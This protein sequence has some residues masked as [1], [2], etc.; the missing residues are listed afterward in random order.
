MDTDRA[1]GPWGPAVVDGHRVRDREFLEFTTDGYL[2]TDTQGVIVEANRA[3]ATVLR[4]PKEFLIS[5]PLGLFMTV[6][7]R[8]RFYE[9]LSRLHAGLARDEFETR[10]GR[11][12][13][14]QRD[15]IV[16]VSSVD[17]GAGDRPAFRWLLRDITERR[18]AE[19]AREELL[20]RLVT[21]QE[22][23]RRRVAREL[24]DSV[25]QLLSAL[26]LG[27]RAVKDAG[28]LPPG[29]L[30]RLEEVNR[31]VGE[32][33]RATHDLAIGLRPTALDDVGLALALRQ[34]LEEWSAR[35][36]IE[37]QYEAVGLDSSRLPSEIETALYRVVQEALTNVV[38]H[39][40]ARRVSVVL[41]R[42]DGRAIAVVEDNGVGF[43]PEAAAESG[44]LGLIGM[45]ERVALV[46]GRLE[47][48][49][50]PGAGTTL[51]V[52]IPL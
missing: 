47:I 1:A 18:R 21:A 37:V 24:H 34:Y 23:E 11:R 4:C 27:V 10:V 13:G 14:E 29:A 48:E 35:T 40:R 36:G 9:C 43:D 20:R 52:Q 8:A 19:A 3:A 30:D 32:L 39:S 46:G 25:G 38:R 41:E 44:R 5:K 17:G 42:Q 26:A 7:H 12:Q 2:L 31:L 15:L 28:P 45:H 22:D 16:W 33:G 6:G 51:I 50:G 49:S